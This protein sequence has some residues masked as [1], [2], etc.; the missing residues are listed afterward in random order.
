[1][2]SEV[3]TPPYLKA[4][5]LSELRVLWQ[6]ILTKNWRWWLVQI[7]DFFCVAFCRFFQKL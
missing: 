1:M 4:E 2:L 7:F 5:T 3:Y 6:E